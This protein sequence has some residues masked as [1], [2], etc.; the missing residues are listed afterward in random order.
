M[1]RNTV[2]HDFAKAAAAELVELR[3]TGSELKPNAARFLVGGRTCGR[4]GHYWDA[5]KGYAGTNFAKAAR[6]EPVPCCGLVRTELRKRAV[7]G[8]KPA[9][10]TKGH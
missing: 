10:Q 5:A 4:W 1:S 9:P 8:L 6:I 3:S 2:I 7:I